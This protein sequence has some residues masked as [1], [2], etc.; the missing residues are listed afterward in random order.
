MTPRFPLRSTQ[1]AP[2]TPQ[3]PPSFSKARSSLFPSNRTYLAP[4][5]LQL[6]L[7]QIRSRD[8]PPPVTFTVKFFP[9]QLYPRHRKRAN[10]STNGTR[11]RDMATQRRR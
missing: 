6:T 4:R 3:I 11:S 8:P 9:Y 10:T 5:R 2:G 7:A 1:S